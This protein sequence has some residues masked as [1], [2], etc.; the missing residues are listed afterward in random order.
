VIIHSRAGAIRLAFLVLGILMSAT[1]TTGLRADSKDDD[2]NFDAPRSSG[3]KSGETP[4]P[5]TSPKKA[6]IVIGL[7]STRSE[8]RSESIGLIFKRVDPATKAWAKAG[9]FGGGV[10][11]FNARRDTRH[12]VLHYLG[13]KIDPTNPEFVTHE[14][15]PGEWILT[16]LINGTATTRRTESTQLFRSKDLTPE[17]AVGP[18]FRVWEGEVVYLGT[19]YLD[20]TGFPAKFAKHAIDEQA[21]KESLKDQP[22]MQQKLSYR[23][24]VVVRK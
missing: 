20:V 4:S 3:S 19:F 9:L 1:W 18:R 21:A 6:V 10:D 22:A 16:D 5:Q 24:P 12:G 17:N 13:A 11:H 14:I 7:A 23:A 15:N 2:R 8:A